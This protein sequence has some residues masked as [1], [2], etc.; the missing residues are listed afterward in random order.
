MRRTFYIVV[1]FSFACFV[2]CG[3]KPKEESSDKIFYAMEEKS[4]DGLRR[5]Q[6]AQA[7]EDVVWKGKNYHI[8]IV[9]TPDDSLPKVKDE[10]GSLFVDNAIAVSVKRDKE[11]GFFFRKTFTKQSLASVLEEEFVSHAILEGM[12]FDKVTEQG[13]VFAASVS[14]PQT[15]LFVPVVITVAPNGTMTLRKEVSWEENEADDKE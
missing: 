4:S 14:Y 3:K 10:E 2:S 9:R 8:V 11:E 15:D 1:L 6:A 7:E 12:A 5:M 13:M